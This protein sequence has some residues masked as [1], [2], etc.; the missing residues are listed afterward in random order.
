MGDVSFNF[1]AML[2]GLQ[3]YTDKVKTQLKKLESSTGGTVKLG[4]MFKLQFRMQLLS[5]YT[6]A[7]S[8]TLTAVNQE[9]VTMARATK[10]Q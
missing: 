5:Q 7:V 10:G 2:K 8:N 1:N 6:E 3:S 9:M 4:T